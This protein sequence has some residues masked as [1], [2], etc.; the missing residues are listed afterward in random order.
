MDRARPGAH[1]VA[2]Q[3]IFGVKHDEGLVHAQLLGGRGLV[4]V[5]IV[6]AAL[7][8]DLLAPLAGPV[9]DGAVGGGD[10]EGV[11][12]GGRDD[13]GNRKWLGLLQ[14]GGGGGGGVGLTVL[15]VAVDLLVRADVDGGSG[16][17]GGQ[18][19][20]QVGVEHQ[21]SVLVHAG[22]ALPDAETLATRKEERLRLAG[23]LATCTSTRLTGSRC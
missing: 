20:L 6:R 9:L 11:V 8:D 18:A 1:G 3:L 2:H 13:C 16:R 21:V 7:E 19:A 4:G 22:E 10:G 14:A 5:V 17:D 12:G 23:E 15:L